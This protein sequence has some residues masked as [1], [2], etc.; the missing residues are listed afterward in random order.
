MLLGIGQPVIFIRI[1]DRANV[2][3][4][5]P[6]PVD[7]SLHASGGK[8]LLLLASLVLVLGGFQLPERGQQYPG[9]GD[10]LIGS[11]PEAFVGPRPALLDVRHRRAVTI[12]SNTKLGLRQ[13]GGLAERGELLAQRSTLR[14]MAAASR[15]MSSTPSSV[16]WLLPKPA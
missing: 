6:F 12:G 10:G 11:P 5:D 4:D 8:L 9:S 15:A 13:V 16:Q 7:V 14:G 2:T 3:R 1:E